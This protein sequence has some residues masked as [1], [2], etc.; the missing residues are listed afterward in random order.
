MIEVFFDPILSII[1]PIANPPM[2][3]PKPKATIPYKAYES[4][5][6]SERSEYFGSFVNCYTIIGLNIPL[7]YAIDTPVIII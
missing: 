7:K 6:F 3:S 1:I 4:Y 5:Y 2:T